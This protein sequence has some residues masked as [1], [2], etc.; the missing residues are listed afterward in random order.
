MAC[1]DRSSF[2]AQCFILDLLQGAIFYLFFLILV[3]IRKHISHKDLQQCNNDTNKTINTAG[4]G[5][6]MLLQFPVYLMHPG[7]MF[8]QV[9]SHLLK[10]LNIWNTHI[11]IIALSGITSSITYSA[12][13]KNS[14]NFVCSQGY[15]CFL[16]P[17]R[18]CEDSDWW[19]MQIWA[20]APAP[21]CCSWLAAV[22]LSCS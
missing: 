13:C 4:K 2:T 20:V 19:K 16:A 9:H 3:R 11:F 1:C 17:F 10:F 22:L 18:H 12:F 21:D 15:F 14:Q 8:S 7:Q 5:I 6:L